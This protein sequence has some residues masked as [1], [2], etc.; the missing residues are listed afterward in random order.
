MEFFNQTY[1]ALRGPTGVVQTPADTI[2]KLSD[3]LSPATLLADRRAAVL[4]LKGLSRDCKEDVGSFALPGL[5][6]VLTNDAEVDADIGKAVLETLNILC[7]TEDTGNSAKALGF[8]HTDIVLANERATHVLLS[9]LKENNFYNRYTA[10]Q[11][12]STLLHNRRQLV[13]SYFLTAPAGPGGIIGVLDDKR[14]IIR[15]EVI[16][17]LQSLVSQ[18]AEIQKV[19]I[20]EGAF[21][22]FFNIITQENGIDGGV[23]AQGALTCIDSLLRFNSSNQ[24]YFKETPLFPLLTQLLQYPMALKLSETAPQDFALQFWDDQ[25]LANASLVVG[26]LGIFVGSK[27]SGAEVINISRCFLE[28]ALASNAPT[29]LKVQVLHSLPPAIHSALSGIA[30]TPYMPVPETNGEEWDRLEPASILDVLVELALHGEYNGQDGAKR[31]KDGLELRVSAAVVFENFVRN[32]DTRLAIIQAMAPSEGHQASKSITPLLHALT[33]PLASSATLDPANVTSTQMA[34]FLFAHLLRSSPRTKDLARLIMPQP[35]PPTQSSFFVP[36]DGGSAPP[37]DDLDSDPPQS[38]LQTLSEHLSLALLARS[39]PDTSDQ[40]LREWDRVLVAYTSLLSQWLW[41]DPKSVRDFLDAGGLSVLVE[42]IHQASEVDSF[43]PG[44]CVFLLG[45]CYEFNREPGE[46]TRNT[47]HPILGRLGID[48]LIGQLTRFREDPRFRSV[49]PDLVVISHSAST[50]PVPNETGRDDAE[51]WFDWAFVDFWK[52]NYYAV[53]RAFSTDPSQLSTSTSGPSA[54]SAM[55]IASL[56]DAI[57]KQSEEM[58]ILR[59]QLKAVAMSKDK[60]IS[61]LQSELS[62]VKTQLKNANDKRKEVEKEQEDLLVLLDE[63]T[64]KRTRDKAKLKEAG[65]EVSEDEDE[66]DEDEDDE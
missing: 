31:T 62:D 37:D 58:D 52:S 40:E 46:I 35:A 43:I 33:L 64:S 66:D 39:R 51:V 5:I 54:E 25:K 44:L 19:L 41:E 47:I 6:D 55:L 4:S 27:S 59:N 53:Q 34:T 56:R 24:S 9:L 18:S 45:I 17:V 21:E 22:K 3:R 15:N 50:I 16:S 38:L 12:L 32:E 8:K 26:I 63:T 23:V 10:L 30:I 11:F 60:E 61:D 7:D 13:Q 42:G 1:V 49:G 20:F 28:I 2:S 36:A 65:L 48:S 57:R 29:P 14:E